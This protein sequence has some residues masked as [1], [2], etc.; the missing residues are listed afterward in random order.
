VP[1]RWSRHRGCGSSGSR[2]GKLGSSLRKDRGGRGRA[3]QGASEAVALVDPSTTRL[4]ALDEVRKLAEL[5][6]VGIVTQEEFDNAKAR[7]LGNLSRGQ[8]RGPDCVTE[9]AA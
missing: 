5:R 6:D 9:P 7:L 1:R 2:A 8:G 3:A 4:S